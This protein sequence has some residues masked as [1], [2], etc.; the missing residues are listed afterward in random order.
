MPSDDRPVT[1]ILQDIMRNIED[2]V[3]AEVRLAKSEMSEEFA[4]AQ[5][6]GV[7]LGLGT[8]GGIFSMFFLLLAIVFALS[9]R[10]PNWAAALIVALALAV[11]GGILVGAGAKRLRRLRSA[12]RPFENLKEKF[13]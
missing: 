4:K 12:S 3:R 5:S 9:N 11:I 7:C 6:A 1:D 13:E 10:L 8:L 2:I